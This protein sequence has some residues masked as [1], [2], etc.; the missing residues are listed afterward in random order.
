MKL[1]IDTAN[2]D[3]IRAAAN[4]GL[5]DGATTNPS[6]IKKEFERRADSVHLQLVGNEPHLVA[7][8]GRTVETNPVAIAATASTVTCMELIGN[9]LPI[10]DG[11]ISG[12]HPVQAP[13]ELFPQCG[14]NTPQSRRIV[15]TDAPHLPSRVDPRVG[16]TRARHRDLLLADQAQCALDLP[17]DAPMGSLSLPSV[18]TGSVVFHC[19]AKCWH[20]LPSKVLRSMEGLRIQERS[21]ASESIPVQADR[22]LRTI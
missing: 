4:L 15:D 18:E 10:P 19:E 5:L 13:Y 16:A 1:F 2:V 11:N 3:E 21:L 9:D 7:V 12:K 14:T 20:A 8:Q 17:L 6:L 22:H